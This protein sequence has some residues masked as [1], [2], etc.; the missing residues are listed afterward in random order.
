MKLRLRHSS[1]LLRLRTIIPKQLRKTETLRRPNLDHFNL[2]LLGKLNYYFHSLQTHN[3]TRLRGCSICNSILP[4]CIMNKKGIILFFHS[5]QILMIIDFFSH[6]TVYCP[7][8]TSRFCPRKYYI[9][10]VVRVVL[11]FGLFLMCRLCIIK[12]IYLLLM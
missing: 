10:K 4:L 9:L 6:Y 11:L 12:N 3:F 1:N 7:A 5:R 2:D 8:Y